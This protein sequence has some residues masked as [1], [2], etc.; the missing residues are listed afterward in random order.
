[1]YLWTANPGPGQGLPSG[2]QFCPISHRIFL[3][4]WTCTV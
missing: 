3:C 4:L 1:M 2:T